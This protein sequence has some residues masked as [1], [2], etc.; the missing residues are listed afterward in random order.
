MTWAASPTRATRARPYSRTASEDSGNRARSVTSRC[1]LPGASLFDLVAKPARRARAGV[2][3]RSCAHPDEA[4]RVSRQRHE[5]ERPGAPVKL[6]AHSAMRAL[7]GEACRHR[8]LIV[9]PRELVVAGGFARRR[10]AAVRG[11]GERAGSSVPSAKRR[12]LGRGFAETDERPRREI[13]SPCL[14]ASALKAA[15]RSAFVML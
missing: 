4:R 10:H 7:M 13:W 11:D 2:P 15:T 6:D 9:G 8:D 1:G 12:R 14:S 5:R 3:P